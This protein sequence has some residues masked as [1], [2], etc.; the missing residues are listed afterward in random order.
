MKIAPILM[1]A[2]L[3]ASG[4]MAGA[5][6]AGTTVVT[7]DDLSDGLVPAVYDGIIW[8]QNWEVYGEAQNPYTPESPP[9][10]IFTNYTYFPLGQ[11]GTDTFSFVRRTGRTRRWY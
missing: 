5:A 4:M 2:T 3:V 1:G 10:R 7:F 8:A 11:L 9:N 6:N